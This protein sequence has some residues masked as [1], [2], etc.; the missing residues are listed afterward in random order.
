MITSSRGKALEAKEEEG[1]TNNNRFDSQYSLNKPLSSSTRQW[2]EYSKNPRIV[3]VSRS[4]G[5]KDRHSKVCTIRGLRDRRIRLSVPTAI[6]LYDLQEKLGLGQPSKVIDWLIDAA[7][8]DIDGLPPLQLPLGFGTQFHHQQMLLNPHDYSSSSFSQSSSFAPLF[9]FDT[10]SSTLSKEGLDKDHR[11]ATGKSRYYNWDFD[12]SL[13]GKSKEV[14]NGDHEEAQEH[15][16]SGFAGHQVQASTQKF[17]PVTGVF[18]SDPYH[19]WEPSNLS[20]SQFGNHEFQSQGGESSINNNNPNPMLLPLSLPLPPSHLFFGPS[21]TTISPIIH[22][23][24]FVTTPPIENQSRETNHF[25]L[26]TS[27]NS[28]ENFVPGSRTIGLPEKHFPFNVEPGFL[29]HLHNQRER[30]PGNDSTRP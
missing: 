7:K 16:V 19:N 26:L 6:Q 17:F 27:N 15:R 12:A 3:R 21:G 20:L 29:Q 30:H 22:H 11:D 2:S 18:N 14:V 24:P 25:S 10:N 9:S 23:P 4:F 8:S 13:R 1:D 28:S 5:G